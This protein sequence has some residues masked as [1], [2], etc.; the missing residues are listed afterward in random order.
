MTRLDPG[1]APALVDSWFTW[2]FVLAIVAVFALVVLTVEILKAREVLSQERLDAV[3]EDDLY[4][5]DVA[6]YHC[7]GNGHHLEADA[8]G[9]HCTVCGEVTRQPL[10]C[11][12]LHRYVTRGQSLTCTVCGYRSAL[13]YDQEASA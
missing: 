2:A 6:E 13:P 10:N 4:A 7:R 12:G 11:G 5:Q 1:P 8:H 9:W 3:L